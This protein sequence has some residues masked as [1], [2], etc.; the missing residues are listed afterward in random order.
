MHPHFHRLPAFIL[1]L[2]ISLPAVAQDFTLSGT[3]RGVNGRIWLIIYDND[4]TPRQLSCR[5]NGGTFAFNGTL[6]KEMPVYAEIQQSKLPQ[7]IP[8]FL[9]ASQIKVEVDMTHPAASRITGSR[10]TSQYRYTLETCQGDDRTAC[11]TTF[12]KDN[13]DQFFAPYILHTLSPSLS[14]E[15]LQQCFAALTGGA[16]KSYHYRLLSRK[17]ALLGAAMEGQRL[18]DIVLPLANGHQMHLDSLRKDSTYLILSFGATWCKSCLAGNRQME[19]IVAA[20]NATRHN[21]KSGVAPVRLVPVMIDKDERKWDNPMLQQLAID[22]IPYIIILS[23]QGYTLKRDVRVW[24][25]ER[26]LN[27]EGT[28]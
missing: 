16:A 13:P 27:R 18:P 6:G 24:E 1:W 9:D 10:A 17:M 2:L 23:P 25:L 12:V 3:L 26:V 19:K 4:S 7:P 21:G 28:Y 20:T 5:I 11:L 15:E 22:Y 8:L 14:Y